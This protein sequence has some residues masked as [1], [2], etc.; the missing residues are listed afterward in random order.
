M[1][2]DIYEVEVNDSGLKVGDVK[3]R[4]EAEELILKLEIEIS[5]LKDE[6]DQSRTDYTKGEISEAQW[7]SD[8][9][10]ALRDAEVAKKCLIFH[11]KKLKKDS[12][13]TANNERQ[14]LLIRH[15]MD[16]CTE[17]QRV[18]A[19]MGY[20]EDYKAAPFYEELRHCLDER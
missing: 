19:L 20:Q 7:L 4:G 1:S 12:L 8:T 10:A 18:K 5:D 2:I 3:T 14:K 9:R 6:L 17:E 13:N 16:V 11:A 15:L